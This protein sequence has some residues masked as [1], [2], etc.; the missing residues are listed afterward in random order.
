MEY[1]R[2]QSTNLVRSGGRG[3]S[4]NIVVVSFLLPVALVGPDVLHLAVFELHDL[5]GDVEV[6]VV[7]RGRDH[8]P[9][10]GLERRQELFVQEAAE[11]GIL[12]GRQLVEDQDRPILEQRDDE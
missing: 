4:M 8:G 6:A 2:N 5:V 9:S 7:V 3:G 12:V 10:L 1:S 11:L